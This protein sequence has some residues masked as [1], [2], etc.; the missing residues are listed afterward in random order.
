MKKIFFSVICACVLNISA[1]A[2]FIQTG[3]LNNMVKIT[4]V[5]DASK[6]HDDSPVVLQGNIINS[7]GDEKYTFTDKTG[8]III[9][10]D[11]EDWRGI[12][13]TPE[14]TVEIYGEVDKG[15][16]KKTKIEVNSIKIK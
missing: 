2:D 14:T 3:D 9:E 4:T 15:L 16:F 10:I 7:L 8:Q 11:D 13:V 1:N 6:L 12:D 5:Q